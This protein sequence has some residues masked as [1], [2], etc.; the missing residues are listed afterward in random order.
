MAE[1]LQ[2]PPRMRRLPLD[3]HNRPVPWFVTWFDG[4]PDFRVADP[5]KMREA[6]RLKLCWVCGQARGAHLGFVLG[7]MCGINRTTSEPPAHVD[8]A[9]YSARAC[10]FLSNPAMRRRDRNLPAE[11]VEAAGMPIARNPGVALVWVTRSYAPF[12]VPKEHGGGTLFGIGAAERVEWW[13]RGRPA[14]HAEVL[15][16]LDAG[17]PTLRATAETQGPQAV[18][19]LERDY[20]LFLPLLPEPAGPGDR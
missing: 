5:V 13:A 1:T 4:V 6:H 15:A 7:P 18:A 14:T 3:K 9:T 2:M 12:R 20:Q 8:C 10:P 19:A 11:Y 17:M 16:S